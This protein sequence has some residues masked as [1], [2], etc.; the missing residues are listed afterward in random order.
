MA[1]EI[2]ST[3]LVIELGII[4]ALLMGWQFTLGRVRRRPDHDR[5]AGGAVPARSSARR[6]L[7]AAREQADEG[8]RGLDGGPCRDGH[9]RHGERH[10]VWQR[11]AR[12]TGFTSVSHIFVMEWAAV[13]RDIVDRPADRRRGR[14][15]GARTASGSRSS[16]STTRLSPRS[17]DRSSARSSR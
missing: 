17:G 8:L 7:D 16:S 15:L 13:L 11:L 5:P 4:L 9:V 3:N 2:A 14:R 1:F 10:A 6:L 12:R